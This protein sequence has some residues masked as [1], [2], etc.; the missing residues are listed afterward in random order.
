MSEMG[1]RVWIPIAASVLLGIGWV[2]F[3]LWHT[4]FWSGDFSFFQNIVIA[5]VSF[6]VAA[7]LIAVS[8]IVWGIR[9]WRRGW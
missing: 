3:I 1:P 4:A 5:L 8:W 2:L 7:G 6:L 9:L